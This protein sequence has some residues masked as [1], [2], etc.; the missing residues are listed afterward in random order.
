MNRYGE[1]GIIKLKNKWILS[2]LSTTAIITLT[3]CAS[4]ESAE[5]EST[6]QDSNGDEELLIYSNSLTEGRQDWIDEMATEAGFNL[7]YVEAGGGDI[8]NRLLAEAS[9]PQADVAFGMDEAMFFQLYNED[10]LVEHEP[11]W[12]NEIPEEANIGE[13]YFHPLVEQRI[14]M[15]YNPEFISEDVAPEN[16][17]D[18]GNT[19]ELQGKYRIPE[20]LGGGTN[21]KSVLSIL[22]QYVDE[23]GELGIA[24]EGWDEVEKFL[25]NGYVTPESEDQLQNFADG[26]VPITFYF[27]GGLPTAEE[28]YE[29]TAQPVDPE[30]GVVT[31]R[32]QIG[33]INKGDDQDYSQAQ[34]FV[35]WFGSAEV[36]SAFVEEFGGQPVNEQ[37]FESAPERLIEIAE[38]TTPMDID[39]NFVQENLNAWMEKVELELMP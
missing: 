39:W 12:V 36:Q 34:E 29:F 24:Q 38:E 22:L 4:G 14:F 1:K 28:E 8:F 26:S 11:E 3:A 35:D 17:Q 27:S 9:A 7:Q 32:E 13:G 10:L 20:N 18:L 37:A 23:D 6:D 2:L 19:P 5:G 31:M 21:Q 15:M 25:A 30:Q 33:V 16:W